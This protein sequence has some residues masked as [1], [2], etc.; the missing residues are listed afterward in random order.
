MRYT[1]SRHYQFTYTEYIDQPFL[2]LSD[3]YCINIMTIIYL[4]LSQLL[5]IL[6]KFM[7]VLEFQTG[8]RAPVS[9]VVPD[10]QQGVQCRESRG[11][12]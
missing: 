11:V 9:T 8:V 12:H 5:T 10:H 3:I 1:S 2:T 4:N 7:I 6:I